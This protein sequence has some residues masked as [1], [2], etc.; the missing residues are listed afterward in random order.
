MSNG[1]GFIIYFS[2]SVSGLKPETSRILSSGRKLI[3]GSC[4]RVSM[5]LAVVGKVGSIVNG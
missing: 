4:L 1:L 5:I 3:N 2:Y